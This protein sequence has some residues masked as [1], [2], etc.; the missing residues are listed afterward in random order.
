MAEVVT[1]FNGYQALSVSISYEDIWTDPNVRAPDASFSYVYSDLATP[2]PTQIGCL[3]NWNGRCRITINYE[4]AIQP[5]WDL[6]R[7]QLDGMGNLIQDTTCVSCHSQTDSMGQLQVPVAQLELVNTP[8]I[9]EPEH[10]T[11]YRELFFGDNAQELMN[12]ALIDQLVPA[13]DA[14][15]NPIYETDAD[16][17]LILDPQG[18][19]IP[20]METVPISAAMNV[21]AAA[22]NGRFFSLFDQGGSHAGWLT[23]A[24]LKL[25]AELIDIGGQYYNNPFDVPQ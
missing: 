14:D 7:Q 12:G 8:S 20:V 11:S 16:G 15:G 25:I 6:P 19:P 10:L 9:D 18:N 24:E 23:P 17:N 5:I 4:D 22:T 3:S 1:R 21:N 2:L 13:L